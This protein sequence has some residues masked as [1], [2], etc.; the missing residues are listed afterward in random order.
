VVELTVPDLT[1][2]V[3]GRTLPAM[4]N[5]A[6]PTGSAQPADRLERV[7][8]VSG[9][10]LVVDREQRVLL[11]RGSD[12]ANS[13]AGDWWFTPGGGLDPGETTEAGALRELAEETG[14]VLEELG[15]PVWVR[16]AEFDFM[17][18]SYR[19]AETFFLV[20][21]GAHE[22]DFA[23]FT[24]LERR[25]VHEFRWWGVDELA[26]SEV[27]VYPSALAAELAALLAGGRP[28][29]AKEVGP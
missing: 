13:A 9:R 20:E 19:Q 15:G 10:V 11:L 14:L 3:G 29:V 21:I 5:A 22:V 25:A 17:G 12:P 28:D 24:D 7:D 4:T 26:A 2:A 8:R 6:A 18:Q 16:T 27:T 1:T 23:G